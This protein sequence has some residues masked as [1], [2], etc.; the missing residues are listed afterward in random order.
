MKE[1]LEMTDD[2][3]KKKSELVELAIWGF[4]YYMEPHTYDGV[5]DYGDQDYVRRGVEWLKKM[6]KHRR[7]KQKPLNVFLHKQIFQGTALAYQMGGRVNVKRIVDEEIK[8]TGW[9]L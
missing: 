6:S 3:M 2:E 1:S 8:V 9:V 7:M 5:F 4:H